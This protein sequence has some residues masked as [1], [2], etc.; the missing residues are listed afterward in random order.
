MS[1]LRILMM[2]DTA[3]G[4]EREVPEILQTVTGVMKPCIFADYRICIVNGRRNW[5]RINRYR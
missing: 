2:K 3:T 5:T 1:P 4:E